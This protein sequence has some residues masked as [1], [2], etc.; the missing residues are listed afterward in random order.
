MAAATKISDGS[1][2][3]TRSGVGPSANSASSTP[4]V[5]NSANP[6]STPAIRLSVTV[7]MRSVRLASNPSRSAWPTSAGN[8]RAMARKPVVAIR[9]R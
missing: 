1:A 5:A 6:V 9:S 2:A 8:R 3:R 4:V 7:A